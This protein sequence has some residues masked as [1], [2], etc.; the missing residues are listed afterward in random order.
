MPQDATVLDVGSRVGDTYEV[1]RLIGRGGMG[2]VW[3][4][5]HLRLPGKQVA[6]KVLHTKAGGL[7][8]EQLVRFKREA[9][10]ATR[11]GHPNIVEVHDYNT[12][13][14]GA[15]YL[16]LEYLQGE[17]L[18]SRLRFGALG[19]DEATLL[20]RQV[21][22]ALDASHQ[23]GVVHRDLK[24]DNI[25]LVA[26]PMGT[27]VKVL[28]FGISKVVDSTT[29]QTA[30][31][32]LVGTPQYMSPEQAVGQNS[33]VGPQTDVFAL[34]SIAYEMLSGQ[35][36]FSAENVAKVLFRIAYEPHV[37]LKQVKPGLPDRVYDAVERALEK[38]RAKRF[39]S[40]ADFI[41]AFSG[42]PV[43]RTLPP[44]SRS[45]EPSG[46][47]RPGM[48]TPD[49]LALGATAAPTPALPSSQA[50]PAVMAP[51]PVA[52]PPPARRSQL[53][54]FAGLAFAGI[55]GVAVTLYVV[56]QPP[57]PPPVSQPLP[58]TMAEKPEPAKPVEL[59]AAVSPAVPSP[60][61]PVAAPKPSKPKKMSDA[62]A[63]TIAEM[64]KRL[65]GK[66]PLHRIRQL[67]GQLDSEPG[68]QRAYFIAGTAACRERDL[69]NT[70]SYLDRLSDRADR[71]RLIVDC[72]KLGMELV[73]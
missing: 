73:E 22:S 1:V 24:P 45:D 25:F 37:P 50:T 65:A 3:L 67:F 36:P 38:D 20:L 29:V 66:E 69:A 71:Q 16:V 5:R 39:S 51:P 18:A 64:E 43:P 10:V 52:A 49:S 9:D 26:A 31:A 72:K 7:S 61:E 30:D 34:G 35:P 55:A 6:I 63:A 54:L 70:R 41:A 60:A 17:S 42:Q 44:P 46:V 68:K 15:P 11:I 21:G 8:E 59:P 58:E 27:Q 19:V 56:Q 47:A 33:D 53:G 2:E 28:D 48:A 14:G 4:A 12:L 32:V 40:I 23:L 62:D 57:P 13:P